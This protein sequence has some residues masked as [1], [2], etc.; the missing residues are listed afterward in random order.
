MNRLQELYKSLRGSEAVSVECLPGAGSNRAYYRVTEKDGSTVIGVIGTSR[1]ENAAFIT[2]ARHFYDRG[3]PVP[4]VLAVSDDGMCYLQ[5]DLG[6][7]ALFDAIREGRAA[8]EYNEMEEE[9]L[10]RT[11]RQLP[12][13]QIEGAR[14]LDFSVC[15]PQPEFDATNVMFDLNYFKY[16]FLKATG[17]DF[18]ELRLEE[19]F[20]RMAS[21]LTSVSNDA[22]MYR[23]FQARNV[24]LVEKEGKQQPYF[25]DFQGGRRGP[26]YYDLASFLWQAS[27]KYPADL[28]ERLINAYYD[29]L[30]SITSSVPEL[31]E[32]TATLLRFV[33]FRTLQVLGAYGFRGYFE[34][35]RHFLDSIPPA[36][37]N[38]QALFN[39]GH[40]DDYPHLKEVCQSIIN[41]QPKPWKHEGLVVRVFSFS[42]KKGIPEDVSGNGGGYVFDCRSTNNPGRY[43]EYKT[44]T[45]R[46]QSVIEFLEKD[47]EILQ[48]LSHIY[49]LVDFHVQRWLD[50]GFTDLQISFGCTGGQHRSV[51]S[52]EHVAHHIHEKFGVK[53]QLCHR[54]QNIYE[55]L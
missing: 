8:G 41:A 18:H 52:A 43:K 28:R 49:P 1:E 12:H 7:V 22:F 51:Y 2:I 17:V 36:L 47:G 32:F 19:E 53:V 35:K 44:V 5:T 38:L 25:I 27:A 30:R 54:E 42:Y 4:E 29:E 55:E 48:F 3:L 34:R 26:V 39:D 16:S 33:L 21:D 15:Y 24:M 37:T 13:L 10:V 20:R 6:A 31:P 14:E 9:L 50:R 46:D 40:C 11:I 23:D 45:G